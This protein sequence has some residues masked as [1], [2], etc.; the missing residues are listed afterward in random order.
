MSQ[1]E[2][3][4]GKISSLLKGSKFEKGDKL[5]I[6]AQ[7]SDDG[8]LLRVEGGLNKAPLAS[9]AKHPHVLHSRSRIARL[10]IQ[11][12]HHDCGQQGMEHVKDHLHQTFL[13]I[14]L[15]KMLRSL[16]KKCFICR[17]WR[18]DNVRPKMADLP[19]FRFSDVN[20]HYSFVKS[21][22]ELLGLFYIEDKREERERERALRCTTSACSPVK[23]PALSTLQSAMTY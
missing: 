15:R 4:S 8:E 22:M 20:K 21:R 19:E 10:M 2:F 11:N 12:A 16:G 1:N 18:A 3:F 23:S 14:G 5:T 13:T 6:F 9:S 17:K 7:F